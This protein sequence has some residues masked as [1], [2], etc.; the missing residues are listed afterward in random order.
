MRRTADPR[1][2]IYIPA[3]CPD[4]IQYYEQL[5][6]DQPHI[7][8][9]VRR[10]TAGMITPEGIRDLNDKPGLLALA[11]ESHTN[12]RTG[13]SDLRGL[14][15]VVPGGR[16][17]EMYGWDSYMESIGLIADGRADLAKSMVQNFCFC[18]KHYGK[19]LN[20]NRTYYLGRTQPP[21]LT[22]MALRVYETIR[23]SNLFR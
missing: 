18:I 16:F 4:Q 3:S 17:N 7:R 8:L 13:V 15:F 11:M 20:A 1:P 5:A 9:D 23:V 6:R 19:I 2:R 14:P 10:L 22:D 21:F 12:T